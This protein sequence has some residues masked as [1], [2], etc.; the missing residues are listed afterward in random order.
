MDPNPEI[1]KRTNEDEIDLWEVLLKLKKGWKTILITTAIFLFLGIMITLTRSYFTKK[2]YI[3]E[4]KLLFVPQSNPGSSFGTPFQSS[5]LNDI[6][7]ENKEEALTTKLYPEILKSNSFLQ[8]L[9]DKKIT[10]LNGGENLTI[11]EYL[12][13][14]L[15]SSIWDYGALKNRINAKIDENGI[16]I[17]NVKMQE[18]GVALQMT[19]TIL[20]FLVKY[21]RFYQ[22]QDAN[23]ELKI[24][25]EQQARVE[26]KLHE[27]Q[28]ALA[29]YQNQHGVLNKGHFQDDEEQLKANYKLASDLYYFSSLQLEQ[30]QMRIAGIGQNNIF[31]V[32]DFPKV[33]LAPSKPKPSIIIAAMFI[34]GL[35]VGSLIVLEKD[36]FRRKN[37]LIFNEKNENESRV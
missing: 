5:E 35:V 14:H 10:D 16:F 15:G 27:M 7:S 30:T 8:K 26:T 1:N 4:V 25:L 6:R 13:K 34:I 12:N 3:S 20:N 23:N 29:H 24:N 2:E 31:Q 9:M 21:I 11:S 19:D 37:T 18:P 22:T 32:F 28:S 36:Y 17:L 33:S